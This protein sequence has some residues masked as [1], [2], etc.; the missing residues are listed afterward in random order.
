VWR[1]G[2][3]GS[4]LPIRLKAKKSLK[5]PKIRKKILHNFS[6]SDLARTA[7]VAGIAAKN[8][9]GCGFIAPRRAKQALNLVEPAAPAGPGAGAGSG[10]RKRKTL[11]YW[12]I[13][14]KHAPSGDIPPFRFH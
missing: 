5:T 13:Q 2:G 7:F 10:V 1:K 11:Q 9:A 6:P 3:K 8:A 14:E 4:R 12:E